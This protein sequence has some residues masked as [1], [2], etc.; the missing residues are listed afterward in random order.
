[1]LKVAAYK[2]IILLFVFL[3][4][5][6]Q[7][8]GIY[9]VLP[10]LRYVLVISSLIL[11]LIGI[12]IFKPDDIN[13]DI[14]FWFLLMNI[15]AL[16]LIGAKDIE[17]GVNIWI[18]MLVKILVVTAMMIYVNSFKKFTYLLHTL[19]IV[20]AIIALHGIL[21]FLLIYINA[22]EPKNIIS[23]ETYNFE[24][25]GILGITAN[26]FLING[27]YITRV[28]SFF[29]EPGYYAS[30]ME[31]CFLSFMSI[32][33]MVYKNWIHVLIISL[34]LTVSVLS[35]SPPFIMIVTITL[36]YFGL[37]RKDRASMVL[38]IFF[39][40]LLLTIAAYNYNLIVDIL[41]NPYIQKVES[42]N[43]RW[44]DY[45]AT[46]DIVTKNTN[47][48][49]AIG[50]NQIQFYDNA[51]RANNLFLDLL[52]MAGIGGVLVFA[53]YLII[54]FIRLIINYKYNKELFKF[55]LIFLGVFVHA[56]IV[57]SIY[58]YYFWTALM[59][60]I[61]AIRIYKTEKGPTEVLKLRGYSS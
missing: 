38:L 50:I 61:I 15:I 13:A 6:T 10:A 40:A 20:G 36:C 53:L 23:F 59:I 39:S 25:F 49:S 9:L 16:Q 37:I 55:Y 54:Y 48:V 7:P 47:L 3:V 4:A 52:L 24:N 19:G 21:Q 29:V 33:N 44:D 8:N 41:T 32:K 14:L 5:F 1:M 11:I 42:A 27:S 28:S 12:L 51:V 35:F 34:Y 45:R 56:L 26:K 30:F 2:P 43:Q 58:N 60:P 17:A 18:S 46:L 31:L 57:P 22:I